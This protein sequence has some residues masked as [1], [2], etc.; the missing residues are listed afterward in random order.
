[1]LFLTACSQI[2]GRIAYSGKLNY[3]LP[4][5]RVLAWEE[6]DIMVGETPI[7]NVAS[8]I[9][10]SPS[11]PSFIDCSPH[12]ILGLKAGAVT[13][14]GTYDNSPFKRQF[15]NQIAV[16]VYDAVG[17]D[18]KFNYPTYN[19]VI[20]DSNPHP[21]IILAAYLVDQHDWTMDLITDSKWANEKTV[22]YQGAWNNQNP[23]C[24]ALEQSGAC[25]IITA[26]TEGV[27][28]ISV[29]YGNFKKICRVTITRR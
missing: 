15:E 27:A 29:A 4:V 12:G 14:S 13:V 3:D 16:N 8:D 28:E 22:C 2:D 19:L 7:M 26:L 9:V 20:T 24:A 10:W 18:I 6:T 11:D 23:E 17:T 21:S 25:G 5:G 1:M